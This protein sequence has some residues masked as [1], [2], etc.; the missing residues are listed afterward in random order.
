MKESR[1]DAIQNG[2]DSLGRAW[3][4]GRNLLSREAANRYHYA[5]VL[6]H[7]TLE[8]VSVGIEQAAEKAL[9][10]SPVFGNPVHVVGI[11]L[12]VVEEHAGH[13][14]QAANELGGRSDFV[15]RKQEHLELESTGGV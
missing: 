9:G 7:L 13:T 6:Q 2:D 4:M 14:A 12:R 3:R 11:E 1:I 10:W 8:P 15:R 5:A